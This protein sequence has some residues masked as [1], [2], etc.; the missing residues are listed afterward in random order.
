[1]AKSEKVAESEKVYTFEDD[2]QGTRVSLI[3]CEFGYLFDDGDRSNRLL[4]GNILSQEN[5]F[6]IIGSYGE[7]SPEELSDEQRRMENP[8]T[9]LIVRDKTLERVVDLFLE[10]FEGEK[11]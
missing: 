6:K 2:S 5:P 9:R 1:M 3:I 10:V 8:P 7:V 4:Y 11:H